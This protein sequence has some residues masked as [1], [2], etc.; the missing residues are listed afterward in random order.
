[1]NGDILLD[2]ED[3]DCG[4]CTGPIIKLDSVLLVMLMGRGPFGSIAW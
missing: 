2:D 1:M 3:N 4:G